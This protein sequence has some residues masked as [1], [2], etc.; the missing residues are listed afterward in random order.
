M[1]SAKVKYQR[2]REFFYQSLS[3]VVCLILINFHVEMETFAFLSIYTRPSLTCWTRYPGS[4]S[5]GSRPRSCR[6]SRRRRRAGRRLGWRCCRWPSRRNGS[7]WAS[8]WPTPGAWAAETWPHKISTEEQTPRYDWTEP[9][10]GLKK[11]NGDA[12]R[13]ANAHTHTHTLAQRKPVWAKHVQ[14][15]QFR[16][17]SGHDASWGH[18][19]SLVCSFTDQSRERSPVAW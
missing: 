14:R 1:G 11:H 13:Q 5:S 17:C 6:S 3:Y 19:Q 8:G 15:F 10:Q 2:C 9:S 12:H 4:N 16:G 7:K 18:M